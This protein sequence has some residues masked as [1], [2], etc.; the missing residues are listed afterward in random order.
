MAPIQDTLNQLCC[1]LPPVR[2]CIFDMDGL[3]IDSEDLYS[4]VINTILKE[5]ERPPMPW[6]IK[7]QLQGRPA[8][9]ATK[10]FSE[11]AQLPISLEEFRAKQLALQLELFKT[12]KPLPGVLELMNNL[13]HRATTTAAR[14]DETSNATE[15]QIALATSSH[16]RLYQ[17]KTGHLNELFDLI[18]DPHKVLGDDPRIPLGRGKPLPDIYLV[19]L[20]SI[21]ETLGAH[22]QIKPE[23]CLVFEDSVPGI[24][25]GRRAGMRV[26]WCP[27][28]PLLELYRGREEEVLAGMTGEH[29]GLVG[30]DDGEVGALGD[31]FGEL[32]SSMNDFD[33]AKYGIRLDS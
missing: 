31:G 33:Y 28:A 32:I 11:W 12:T 7:A 21:N 29:K 30:P 2:A 20:A 1:R 13:A 9:E 18:P 6:S 23:E 17:I 5:Y 3:L 8:L 4:V 19:A 14:T 22:E 26:V 27:Y 10:I 15:V 24:E 25:A 16:Q